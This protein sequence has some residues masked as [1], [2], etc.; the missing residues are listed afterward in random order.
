MLMIYIED[1]DSSLVNDFVD[2]LIL[3]LLV[4]P[5][6]NFSPLQH[7]TGFY[8]YS[9]IAFSYRMKCAENYFGPTCDNPVPR[10]SANINISTVLNTYKTSKISP[11]PT[12]C[13]VSINLI[14][15]LTL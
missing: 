13:I 2:L 1:Y 14:H 3:P 6:L 8:N 5:K 10:N 9:F 11:I 12:S 7:Y 4:S 15:C